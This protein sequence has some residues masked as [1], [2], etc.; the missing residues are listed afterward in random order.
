MVILLCF[1]SEYIHILS[2]VTYAF[3]KGQHYCPILINWC[4]FYCISSYQLFSSLPA[5][6]AVCYGVAHICIDGFSVS[7]LVYPL[8]L[9]WI[10]FI[11]TIQKL[12]PCIY[13]LPLASSVFSLLLEHFN[14]A[15]NILQYHPS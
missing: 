14:L 10:P 11:L 3:A 5:S 6:V 9:Y 8:P 4:G 12:C 13:H 1:S 15:Y 7:V 2:E